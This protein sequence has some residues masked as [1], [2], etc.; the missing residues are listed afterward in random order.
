MTPRKTAAIA[1][2][3]FSSSSNLTPS[4]FSFHKFHPLL[5]VKTRFERSSIVFLALEIISLEIS[6]QGSKQL[7]T[8]PIYAQQ[9]KDIKWRRPFSQAVKDSCGRAGG[10]AASSGD[11]DLSDAAA[12][13]GP[14][15]VRER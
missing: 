6:P 8:C 9:R 7:P 13:I 10:E 1:Q 5:T 14:R 11:C 3:T 2:S 4:A 15:P 12:V